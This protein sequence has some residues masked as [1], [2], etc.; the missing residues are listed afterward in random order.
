MKST[1]FAILIL[2]LIIIFSVQATDKDDSKPAYPE[3]S[4][5]DTIVWLS[6]NEALAKSAAKDQH[7]F[8]HFT[9]RTC[10]W[11]RKMERETY[12]DSSVVRMLNDHFAPVKIWA[13]AHNNIDVEGYQ[14]T[15]SALAR[16]EFGVAS[17]PQFWFVN[18]DKMKV[19]PL[20]GYLPVSRFMQSLEYVRS[21]TYDTT[22]T[23]NDAKSQKAETK[24]KK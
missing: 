20:K 14:I 15:Q 12:K 16:Q 22:R 2:S 23:S 10:G 3:T 13:D 21:Y 1:K 9:T 24:N 5:A 7:I 11:C 19:G 4:K 18:P 17:Y 6:Y 8:I